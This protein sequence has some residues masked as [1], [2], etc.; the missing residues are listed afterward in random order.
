LSERAVSWIVAILTG[1]AIAY[2]GILARDAIELALISNDDLA[3]EMASTLFPEFDEASK[4]RV[5]Q[6]LL[7]QGKIRPVIYL[8]RTWHIAAA[9]VMLAG[10]V[11]LTLDKALGFPDVKEQFD[12]LKADHAYAINQARIDNDPARV[13]R[14]RQEYIKAYCRLIFSSLLYACGRGISQR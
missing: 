3:R 9:S 7:D 13:R 5:F 14:L 4:Q 11:A 6:A 2:V 12:A 1:V 8:P 10:I